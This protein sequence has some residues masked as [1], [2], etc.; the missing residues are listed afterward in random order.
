MPNL[1]KGSFTLNLGFVQ[2]GGELADDD[3]Q[4]AWELY[5]EL[6]TRV[7]VVGKP[8]DPNCTNFD[9]ELLIESMY[10]LYG[11]FQEARKIMR[12]FP[13]GKLGASTETHLGVMI[14]HVMSEV[15][16]PFL[17]KWHIEFRHWWENQSN[18][19]IAPMDRQKEFPNYKELLDDW[20]SLRWLMR[21]LQKEIVS[22]YKLTSVTSS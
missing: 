8:S 1:K 18:H 22:V 17:E 12:Q 4:C 20:C 5:T 16:R 2:L 14:S 9:G 10:S 6:S 7:A 15:L 19:R 11:F 13:V 3:R 21:A